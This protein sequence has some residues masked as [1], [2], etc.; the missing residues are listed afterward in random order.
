MLWTEAAMLLCF[1]E[2]Y[3]ILSDANIVFIPID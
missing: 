1:D 3:S 2:E